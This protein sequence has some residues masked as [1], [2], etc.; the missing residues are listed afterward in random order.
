MS[1]TA[2]GL[3]VGGAVGSAVPGVGTALGAAVGAGL[4][5]VADIF[6][7]AD[8]LFPSKIEKAYKRSAL[9]DLN[10]LSGGKG[11]MSPSERMAA[12]SEAISQIDASVQESQRQMAR[13]ASLDSGQKFAMQRDLAKQKMAA[14]QQAMSSIRQQ[15]LEEA[16]RQR[17]EAYQKA[18]MAQGMRE[19]RKAKKADFSISAAMAFGAGQDWR[20]SLVENVKTD[21]PL[22]DK[23]DWKDPIVPGGG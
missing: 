1:A 15:N 18:A 23:V 8:T 7:N 14:E 17:Q 22:E 2:T 6:S 9:D 20:S 12:R 16:Q 21:M 4:G 13:G 3:Q 10:R 11:G 19:R 5:F